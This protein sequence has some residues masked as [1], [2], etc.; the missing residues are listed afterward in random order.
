M[1][2]D[3]RP[4]QA[5]AVCDWQTI[6]YRYRNCAACMLDG[7][8]LARLIKSTPRK[9]AEAGQRMVACAK[10]RRLLKKKGAK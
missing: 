9:Q 5:C 3:S 2:I 1:G 4:S 7:I 8:A 10:E 6:G